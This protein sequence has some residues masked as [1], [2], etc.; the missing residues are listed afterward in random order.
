MDTLLRTYL[1]C[2]ESFESKQTR[3]NSY[4]ELSMKLTTGMSI[5]M[6]L[7]AHFAR[8]VLPLTERPSK[9]I[10]KTEEFLINLHEL[11]V[12]NERTVDQA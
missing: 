1:A 3:E 8:A 12:S 5:L 6:K 4:D 10:F 11:R 7:L 9:A 2:I